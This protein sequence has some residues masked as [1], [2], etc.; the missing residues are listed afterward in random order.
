MNNRIQSPHVSDIDYLLCLYDTMYDTMYD[1]FPSDPRMHPV[2]PADDISSWRKAPARTES[3]RT[4]PV[5]TEA[6]RAEPVQPA[7]TPAPQS[8]GDRYVL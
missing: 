3:A 4:E 7:R 1:A 5:R 6:V 8:A 2:E